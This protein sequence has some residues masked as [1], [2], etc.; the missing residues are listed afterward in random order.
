MV[1]SVF[2][3]T[4]IEKYLDNLIEHNEFSYGIIIGQATRQGKDSVIHLAKTSEGLPNDNSDDSSK[5]STVQQL[6]VVN[7]K[8]INSEVLVDHA[9][10]V[11][12]MIPGSFFVLGIFVASPQ[13]VFDNSEDFKHLK[14]VLQQLVEV[15]KTENTNNYGCSDEFDGGEKLIFHYAGKRSSTCKT[16]NVYDLSKSGG[17]K[18]VD[19][20]FQDKATQWQEFETIYDMDDIYNLQKSADAT[21]DIEENFDVALK[22]IQTKLNASV[23]FLDGEEPVT[24]PTDSVEQ[25]L[26]QKKSR[27]KDVNTSTVHGSIYYL[28]DKI[29]DNDRVIKYNGTANYSGIVCSKVWVA[30]KQPIEDVEKFIKIDILRSVT[31]RLRMYVDAHHQSGQFTLVSEPPRRVFFK[32]KSSPVMFSDYLFRG[33]SHDTIITQAQTHMDIHLDKQNIVDDIETM[34]DEI[35]YEEDI[36]VEN[37]GK[38]P[39]TTPKKSNNRVIYA[40][41]IMC[42]VG[43]LLISV[44]VHVLLNSDNEEN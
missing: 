40:M 16:T 19:W 31:S 15:L 20:K 36:P 38:K 22:S 9:L 30:G 1:R 28:C 32:L 34:S 41:G 37:V 24:N 42:A 33:E 4:S 10:S 26:K 35:C 12:R 7:V 44:G 43:I 25:F 18:P 2:A 17:G 39:T 21:Y 6:E 14:T 5:D 11:L 13:N 29:D 27:D 3:D 8:G 23:V